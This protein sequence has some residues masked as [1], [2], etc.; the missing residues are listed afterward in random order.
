MKRPI[1][2]TEEEHRNLL[3]RFERAC[4]DGGTEPDAW[5][6]VARFDGVFDVYLAVPV[7]KWERVLETRALSHI[8]ARTLAAEAGM[9]K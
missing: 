9:D 3:M 1:G 2:F 8:H 6:S 7:L 5:M 4:G